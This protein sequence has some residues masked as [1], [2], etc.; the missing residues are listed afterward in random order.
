MVLLSQPCVLAKPLPGN[1]SASLPPHHSPS[2]S[3]LVAEVE[4]LVVAGPLLSQGVAA[5]YHPQP[6]SL[7]FTNIP[8]P[9][10]LGNKVEQR[11]IAGPLLSQGVGAIHRSLQRG[12]LRLQRRLLCLHLVDLGQHLPTRLGQQKTDSRS[13][14]EVL[15]LGIACA[16]HAPRALCNVPSKH[17]NAQDLLSKH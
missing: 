12:G 15:S 3:H 17:S 2:P 13:H 7:P 5:P 16:A 14:N 11:V 4:Q 10:H 8:Q 1:I 6:S 9:P